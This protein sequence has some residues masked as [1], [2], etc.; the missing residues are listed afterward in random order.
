MLKKHVFCTRLLPIVIIEI[1]APFYCASSPGCCDFIF[2]CEP[3]IVAS[4][5]SLTAVDVVLVLVSAVEVAVVIVVVVVVV[6]V[7]VLSIVVVKVAIAAAAAA[8]A[9]VVE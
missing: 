8:A 3:T 1:T 2:K 5:A 6:V 9:A 4:V 7:V